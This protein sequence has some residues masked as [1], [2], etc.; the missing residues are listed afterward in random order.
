MQQSTSNILV[1]VLPVFVVS[2]CEPLTIQE[3]KTMTVLLFTICDLDL[4]GAH[5]LGASDYLIA[6][7]Y[8]VMLSL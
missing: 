4:E 3:I 1:I 2:H 5:Q 6:L 7:L 8:F